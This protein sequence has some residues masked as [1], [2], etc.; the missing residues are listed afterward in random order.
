MKSF[1]AT[2]LRGNS[3][4]LNHNYVFQRIQYF[5]TREESTVRVEQFFRSG[6][7]LMPSGLPLKLLI[8]V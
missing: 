1:I 3:F 6:L 4:G 8:T 2:E 5:M 7:G